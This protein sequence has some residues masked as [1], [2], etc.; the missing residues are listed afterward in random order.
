MPK[1]INYHISTQV[2]SS[3][4]STRGQAGLRTEIQSTLF[5]S[6]H[7]I[8]HSLNCSSIFYSY[9]NSTTKETTLNK[10]IRIAQCGLKFDTQHNGGSPGSRK[11]KLMQ[12]KKGPE[13]KKGRHL[14]GV[15]AQIERNLVS[16]R[17]QPKSEAVIL[18]ARNGADGG[19]G[20]G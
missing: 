18:D 13:R 12:K 6:I 3:S 10:N 1:N 17:I 16:R 8:T 2:H 7:R 14:R 11:Q 9:W 5:R 20:R 4:S 15:V 19:P